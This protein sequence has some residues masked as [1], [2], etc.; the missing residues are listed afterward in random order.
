MSHYDS[1]T[2]KMLLGSK[3][4]MTRVIDRLDEM[5]LEAKRIEATNLDNVEE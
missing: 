2:A 1:V 3:F 4:G 5:M